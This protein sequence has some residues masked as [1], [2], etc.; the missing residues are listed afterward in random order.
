MRYVIAVLALMFGYVSSAFAV[1]WNPL[2]W[3]TGEV[4]GYVLTGIAAI[5]SLALGW[6]YNKLGVRYDLIA[7]TLEEGAQFFGV[8][9]A[10]AADHKI[11]KEELAS[12]IKEGQ[13]VFSLYKETPAKYK[14]E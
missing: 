7:K 3:I 10:A 11:T 5:L 2:H 12:I 6:V 4:W 9:G 8:L 14:T 1:D 13:D